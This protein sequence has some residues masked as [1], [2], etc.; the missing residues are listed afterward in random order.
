MF[1]KPFLQQSETIFA[2]T[3]IH[4]LQRHHIGIGTVGRARLTVD[5][6]DVFNG[7]LEDDTNVLGAALFD[8]PGTIHAV[9]TTAGQVVRIESE[10]KLPVNQFIPLTAILLGEETVVDDPQSEIAAARS[11]DRILVLDHGR[12]RPRAMA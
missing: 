10:Y 4:F 6:E 5:G 1:A 9:E 3:R 11:A 2:V 12:L 7:E 8:P